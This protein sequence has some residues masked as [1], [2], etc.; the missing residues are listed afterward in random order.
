VPYAISKIAGTSAAE[1]RALCKET[2]EYLYK[3]A[4]ETMKKQ[5][6]AFKRERGEDEHG[7][8]LPM[9]PDFFG[10]EEKAGY[11]YHVTDAVFKR[12][13]FRI[14]TLPQDDFKRTLADG[15]KTLLIFGYHNHTWKGCSKLPDGVGHGVNEEEEPHVVAVVKANLHCVNLEEPECLDKFSLPAVEHLHSNDDAYLKNIY[16]C[17]TV[18]R[19]DGAPV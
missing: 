8:A 14:H 19:K 1:T 3:K 9:E 7:H 17:Y 16:R 4:L 15:D 2:A 5:P 11:S 13:G 6:T 12:L 18:T 10:N